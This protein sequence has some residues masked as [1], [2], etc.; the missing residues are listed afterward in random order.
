M[1][2]SDLPTGTVDKVPIKIP[3]KLCYIIKPLYKKTSYIK[4]I[5]THEHTKDSKVSLNLVSVK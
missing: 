1:S 5:H 4:R 3:K 2:E